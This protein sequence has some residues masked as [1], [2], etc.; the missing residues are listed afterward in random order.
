[1]Y[2]KDRL[3]LLQKLMASSEPLSSSALAFMLNVSVKT[4][5]KY[6]NQLKDE[7]MENGADILI[8]RGS[9]SVLIVYDQ[10]KFNHYV[11]TLSERDTDTVDSPENRKKYLLARLITE[12]EY[13]NLYD[14][15]DEIYI[16]PSSLRKDLRELKP[17]LERYSL[18]F[19]LKII[20]KGF[21]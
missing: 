9:G 13:L 2:E 20:R 18:I 17:L 21:S 10:E 4:L 6:I 5:L 3:I 11:Q 8:K 7:L 16:S 14:L 19:L 1:M 12:N 15:A